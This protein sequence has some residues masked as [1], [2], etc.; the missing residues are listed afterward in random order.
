MQMAQQPPLSKA[1]DQQNSASLPLTMASSFNTTVPGLT[2]TF[3]VDPNFR[4]GYAQTW[5]ASV[6]QD[7]PGSLTM[8]ATYQGVK[9]AQLM[10]EYL[11]NTEPIGA[12]NPCS[13][14]PT[15]FVYLNS[16]G[17][18][19]RESGQIQVRRRLRN[20]LTATVQY[21]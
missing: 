18:S 4:I 11:P 12:V 15:G 19:T 16:N 13:S 20:G 6:Q 5:N 2:N 10:Q 9:G 1:F 8:T 3:G 17:D 21:T 7:L 14:C